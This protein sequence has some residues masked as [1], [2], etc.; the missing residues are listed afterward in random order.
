[1]EP[2]KKCNCGIKTPVTGNPD[3]TAPLPSGQICRLVSAQDR[4]RKS[5]FTQ[6]SFWNCKSECF[7]KCVC[8]RE[9][10]SSEGYSFWNNW[11][12]SVLTLSLA[13]VQ[14][15]WTDSSTGTRQ[16]SDGGIKT[17]ISWA[18]RVG[19]WLSMT[20]GVAQTDPAWSAKSC[21]RSCKNTCIHLQYIHEW[22]HTHR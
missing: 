18:V 11:R 6:E 8:V 14:Y 12:T 7:L 20:A 4:N 16:Q 2:V 1:M 15:R 19:C 22:T 5:F 21:S 9:R 3:T 10:K 17:Q 13:H